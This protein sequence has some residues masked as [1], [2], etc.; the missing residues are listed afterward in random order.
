[1]KTIVLGGGCFW[2]I[3]A[4]FQKINGVEKVV[5]GY[6]GG[7]LKNPTY[8]E[9]GDH[10]EV[11][12]VTYDESIISLETLLDIFLKVHNPTTVNQ[13]G[14]DIG[15]QYRSLILV[16]DNLEAGIAR[17][18]IDGNQALWDNPIVTTVGLLDTFYPAEDY[19]QDYFNKNPEAGYCQ[20]VINPKLS[21]FRQKFGKFLK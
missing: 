12:Q 2:C 9:L 10:A 14:A 6:A 5:S 13:Q 15:S 11:V 19:H 8:H 3:E 18:V 1:M 4:L 17:K 16:S 20:V 21:H 7:T